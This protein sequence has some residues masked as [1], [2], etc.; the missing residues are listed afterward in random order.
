MP[1]VLSDADIGLGQS[2]TLSDSDIGLEA[3]PK[4][5]AP[6]MGMGKTFLQHAL[7]GIGPGAAF[8]AGAE[9]GAA[10][11]AAAGTAIL[12]GIGT[13]IGGGIGAL[14]TGVPAAW[15]AS[16]LQHKALE[17]VAPEF[18]K[19]LDTELAQGEEQNPL[20][21]IAGDVT[22][23]AP[24]A[25]LAAF[26]LAQLPFRAA[27]GAGVGAGL[28]L[29]EGR[30]PSWKDVATGAASGALFGEA[31]FKALPKSSAAAGRAVSDTLA[32]LGG[33]KTAPGAPEARTGQSTTPGEAP[34]TIDHD[35][36]ERA[37]IDAGDKEGATVK[38][39]D[40][41]PGEKAGDPFHRRIAR[42]TPEGIEVHRGEFAKWLQEVPEEQRQAAV[43][44]LMAHEN[45]HRHVAPEDARSYW[46]TLTGF[47]K[48]M[49][50]RQYLGKGHWSMEAGQKT[51]GQNI[52]NEANMGHEALR[53]R[54]ERL[55]TGTS[56][57]IAEAATKERWKVQTLDALNRTVR[58]IREGLGTDAS[59]QGLSI[60]DRIQGNL[61]AARVAIGASEPSAL[62]KQGEELQRGDIDPIMGARFD[63]EVYGRKMFTAM[64]PDGTAGTTFVVDAKA[65]PEQLRAKYESV[66]ERFAGDK[67]QP[68]PLP[69]AP[70]ALR[71]VGDILEAEPGSTTVEDMDALSAADAAKLFDAKKE[72][73]MHALIPQYD[74]VIAGMKLTEADVPKL[75][76]LR[77]AEGKKMMEAFRNND[78][79]G[80][81]AAFGKNIWYSGAIEGAKR[82]GANYESVV[83]RMQEQ[84]AALRK[85]GEE[86]QPTHWG[87]SVDGEPYGLFA[88]ER[89]ARMVASGL[90][91]KVEIKPVN[92]NDFTEPNIPGNVEPMPEGPAGLRK[93]GKDEPVFP[94]ME[95]TK[96]KGTL[97]QP[98]KAAVTGF[99]TP[100]HPMSE[101]QQQRKVWQRWEITPN[102]VRYGGF[103]DQ[104]QPSY[105]EI[106]QKDLTN[107]ESL[108]RTLTEDSRASNEDPLSATRRVTIA[109][110]RMGRVHAVSTY[111]QPARL[112]EPAHA[113]LLDPTSTSLRGHVALPDFLK[114]FQPIASILLHDPVQKFHQQW[115]S[116]EAYNQAFGQEARTMAANA[117][118]D[119]SVYTSTE[120]EFVPNETGGRAARSGIYQR[121]PGSWDRTGAITDAEAGAI[122]D[123]ITS[124]QGGF[125]SPEDV[126]ASLAALGTRTNRQAVSGYRKLAA[127]LQ[128][129]FPGYSHE[130]IL[131]KLKQQIYENYQA[132]RQSI[133]SSKEGFISRTMEQGGAEN[134]P[135]TEAQTA[136]TESFERELTMPINRVPPTTMRPEQLPPYYKAPAR[137]P[138]PPVP[139][140]SLQGPAG[141]RKALQPATDELQAIG[142]KIKALVGK[143]TGAT[144]DEILKTNAAASNAPHIR[145]RQ[146]ETSIRLESATPTT[147]INQE[148]KGKP[149]ILSAATAVVQSGFSRARIPI[150]L[151]YV[152]NGLIK[153]EAMA[154]SNSWQQRRLGR[155]WVRYQGQLKAELDFANDNWN[156]PELQATARKMKDTLD[157]QLLNERSKGVNIATK[158]DYLPQ[159]YTTELW[160]GD[161]VLIAKLTGTGP[162]VLGKKWKNPAVFKN[163]Y[164]ASAA[165]PYIAVTR[166]GASLVGHRVRQ[167]WSSILRKE[168]QT[169]LQGITT[170]D[171]KPLAIEPKLLTDKSW[172]SPV[173]GYQIVAQQGRKPLAIHEGYANLV[174]NLTSDMSISEAPL[175]GAAL[176]LTQMIKHSLLVGDF[177]HMGRMLY[178][179][180]A[181]M[182]KNAGWKGGWS[183]L[184]I[185]PKDV[186]LAV[187]RGVL[188]PQDAAWGRQTVNFNGNQIT[189]Q[190]LAKKFVGQGAEL[191][192]I[193]DALYKDLIT[194]LPA[195]AG[196]VR[197]AAVKAID[198]TAGRYNRFLFDQLTRGLMMESNVR[199]FERQSKAN[200]NLDHNALVRDI[201]KDVNVFFGNIGKQG[202]FKA[203]WHQELASLLMLAPGWVEGLVKK[204]ANFAERATGIASLR[205]KREGLNTLGTVG[206]GIG[207]GLLFMAGLTQAINLIS[208]GKPT[209][210]NEEEGHKMDA[211]IPG[212]TGEE[213]FWLS[214]MALFNELAHDVYRLTESKP[215]GIE[216]FQQIA[217]NKESP[218]TRAALLA[219]VG[220]SPTGQYQTTSM[221]TLA[222]AAKQLAPVPITFGKYAQLAGNKIAP[223]LVPPPAP[224]VIQRQM[225]STIGVKV[226]P[227]MGPSGEVFRLAKEFMK[228][229]GLEKETGWQQI[230]TDEASYTKLRQTLRNNDLAGAKAN[231]DSLRK[232]HTDQQIVKAMNGWA[233][234]GFT[235]SAKTERQFMASLDDRQ[236]MTYGKAVDSRYQELEKFYD[237]MVRQ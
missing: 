115:D 114:R 15:A 78:A 189:R 191:G 111:R 23:F 188:R 223:G 39:V 147:L 217:G 61:D 179:A 161:S 109:V 46:D 69:E 211:W 202:W 35:A 59:Q 102:D 205:G 100:Q 207:R 149:Q 87:I 92:A 90:S 22:S 126:Q 235:G 85:G 137:R 55:A 139:E 221:G 232:T 13:A 20:S 43:E 91:G 150:F 132:S 110:D 140:G 185:A 184:D 230:Q 40:T 204:E 9:P 96:G 219:L 183:V 58:S 4:E 236:M 129:Q 116:V 3:A 127:E 51:Y 171:G 186:N 159:R 98:T 14:V 172:A 86:D 148:V 8:V 118:Y 57:E 133:Q 196:V 164:V 130:E 103:Q 70:A 145:G 144:I 67:N 56:T 94:G 18:T 187:R 166:D 5:E 206:T 216:A 181:I 30:S 237:W 50:L 124:K 135:T 228:K 66:R 12:P 165:G 31:R 45:I 160:N 125:N 63:G 174:K 173:Q 108:G 25:K 29:I 99:L 41:F 83:K 220:K 121:A 138:A 42:A 224:G 162:D 54:F 190:E 26:K 79:V 233:K 37:A 163:Y 177:F 65:S 141:L 74:S 36:L 72:G 84:P 2:Q 82:Q 33:D 80:Q 73:G 53:R 93:G 208:R 152:R 52:V 88:N 49:E 113:M 226:E 213:G 16:K 157:M 197:R 182:G 134:R 151:N 200:P 34:V 48:M 107:A 192:R 218:L 175:L 117:K 136:P 75:E 120:G 212:K 32:K 95:K 106:G 195:T 128:K 68:R 225:L 104:G 112:G 97:S 170:P 71:K 27:L 203:G 131:N 24:S 10:A 1:D 156:N 7:T 76:K 209:W 199:E 215:K 64:L 11:G 193:Q 222:E 19:K 143:K 60:L 214:P 201:A 6:K 38:I 123:H 44:Q 234:R 155:A 146:A 167:G 158:P 47:E 178:Y 227:K 229:E 169:G 176:H 119:P 194:N 21:A 17:V 28:P 77:D 231:L 153:A 105:K 198:P 81:K 210:Q 142:H 180:S 154:N 168:W 89:Q 62:R 122:I 101:E